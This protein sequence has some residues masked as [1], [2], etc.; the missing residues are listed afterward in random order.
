LILSIETATSTCS[1]AIT[2]GKEVIAEQNYYLDKSH[3]ALLPSIIEELLANCAIAKNELSAVA[4]SEGPGSY[5]G[6]RIG[7]SVAKGLC[8]ALEIP[9]VPI[10]TLE[11][12]AFSVASDPLKEYVLCPML[13]ARRMEVY[14]AFYDKELNELMPLAALPLERKSFETYSEQ[15]LLL[16]GNGAEKTKELF[17][18]LDYVYY[19]DNAM[20]KASSIG[21]LADSVSKGS[22]VDMAYYEPNYF[23]EFKAIKP[24]PLI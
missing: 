16:F 7:T 1:I 13:D 23:K 15:K 18:G 8:F 6:L 20:L 12:L 19:L 22:E 9:L 11:A 14:T 24:K 10:S 2:K 5:T 4:L 21:I 3:S 17:A